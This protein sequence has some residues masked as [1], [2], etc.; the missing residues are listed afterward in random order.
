MNLSEFF[1]AIHKLIYDYSIVGQ[2]IFIFCFAAA[3]YGGYNLAKKYGGPIL[4]GGFFIALI[5]LT[6]IIQ[7]ESLIDLLTHPGLLILEGVII[8]AG[9]H[10]Y[11]RL[12]T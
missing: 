2:G 9:C 5:I 11:Q 4:F 12:L 1:A 7:K 3:A 8:G 10:V 6:A